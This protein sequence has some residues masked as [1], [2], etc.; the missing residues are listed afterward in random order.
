MKNS[1]AILLS[2]HGALLTIVGGAVSLFAQNIIS[3]TAVSVIT[4]GAMLASLTTRA[5]VHFL[6]SDY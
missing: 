1:T 5:L 6:V 4:I 3:D 2:A